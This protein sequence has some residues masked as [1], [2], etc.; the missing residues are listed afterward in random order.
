MQKKLALL[1]AVFLVAGCAGGP[2]GIGPS[3][4]TRTVNDEAKTHGLLF[5]ANLSSNE[6]EIFSQRAGSNPIGTITNGIDEPVGLGVDQSQ[7]LYVANAGQHGAQ[8][9]VTEYAPPYSGA[10]VA[11]YSQG[12]QDSAATNVAIGADG[13]VYVSEYSAG[14]VVEYP[15]RS[16]K[17]SGELAFNNYPG[18]L[19]PGQSGKPEGLALDATNNLYVAVDFDDFDG[20]AE[21]VKF[22]PG[23]KRGH[24]EASISGSS[25][26]VAFDTAGNL[27][28][29]K[30]WTPQVHPRLKRHKLPPA[31][32]VFPPRQRDPSRRI[33]PHF[34]DAFAMALDQSEK[35][36]LVSGSVIILGASDVAG[37]GLDA[38]GPLTLKGGAWVYCISYPAG[39][40]L[41]VISWPAGTWILGVA[42]TPPAPK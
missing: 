33:D 41:R 9:F 17:P 13:S 4:Q 34:H 11:T 18:I 8:G 24:V 6:V 2:T 5:V 31:I 35:R 20:I 40:V 26:G 42:V 19:G 7:N 12:L 38:A 37:L 21:V 25:G 16:T 28:V 14:V 22:K 36:L 39:K 32:Y 29:E 3:Q 15:P 1:A 30:Q 27:L 23:S 10:P